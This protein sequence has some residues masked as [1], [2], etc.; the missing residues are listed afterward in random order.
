MCQPAAGPFYRAAGLT[1]LRYANICADMMRSVL[2]EPFKGK[3]A[4]RAAIS[5]RSSTWKDGRQSPS[6]EAVGR[7]GRVGGVLPGHGHEQRA[8]QH[9]RQ[10]AAGA[11]ASIARADGP[12]CVCSALLARRC[13]S[14]DGD[15]GDA[16]HQVG[17]QAAAARS[18]AAVAAALPAHMCQGV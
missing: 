1:Y 15:Q 6:G 12:P 16:N 17:R 7:V 5:F 4:Q 10:R 14:G 8:W 11:T 3:A 9:T 13:R 2:K 18:A